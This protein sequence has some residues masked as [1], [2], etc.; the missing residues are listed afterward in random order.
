MLALITNMNQPFVWLHFD[1]AQTIAVRLIS[2][3]E[4]MC[5]EWQIGLALFVN[6]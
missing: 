5:E 4:Q 2:E 6:I 3:L 1:A